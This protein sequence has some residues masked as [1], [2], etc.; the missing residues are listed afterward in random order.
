MDPL[1]ESDLELALAHIDDHYRPLFTTLAFT[2]ARPNELLALRWGDIDWVSREIKISKGLVRGNEGEP[3]TESSKRTI[4]MVPRVELEL[5]ALRRIENIDAQVDLT[6][7]ICG[8]QGFT[9]T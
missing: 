2:G 3:K 4:P 7:H 9:D 8:S 6:S 1:E 5:K